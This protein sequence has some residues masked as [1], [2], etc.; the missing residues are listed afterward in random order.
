MYIQFSAPKYN[1]LNHFSMPKII[2][3]YKNHLKCK[4]LEK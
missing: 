3:I 1:I 4:C 2:V